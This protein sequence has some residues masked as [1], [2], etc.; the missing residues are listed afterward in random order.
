MKPSLTVKVPYC[1]VNMAPGTSTQYV[2][3]VVAE[4][5]LGPRP[6]GLVVRHM[7]G[8]RENNAASNLAYVTYEWVCAERDK[9]GHATRKNDPRRASA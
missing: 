7:D 5:F 1:R 4:A 3:H 6:C 8:D 9:F 2:H